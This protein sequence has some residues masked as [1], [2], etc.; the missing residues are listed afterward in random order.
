MRL[1]LGAIE[2]S[3]YQP[4]GEIEQSSLEGLA[5]SLRESGVIQPL[6]VRPAQAP[7][8][9]ELIAG[10]RRWRAAML[11]GLEEVPAIVRRTDDEEAAQLA[12]VENVQ[13]E[14]LNP[15]ERSDALRRLSEAFGWTQRQLA[16]RVGLE[17]STVANLMRLGELEPAIRQMI[18]RNE[19][20][21]GHA[22]A[23]L[24]I[25]AGEARADLARRAAAEG[26]SVRK[27]ES[28]AREPAGA[29]GPRANHQTHTAQA[30]SKKSADLEG[31]ERRLGEHLG[32]RVSIKVSGA[33][34][35]GRISIEFFDLDHFDAVVS[36]MGY[37]AASDS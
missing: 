27:L 36:S 8:R 13:R 25:S 11:A 3:P 31:L 17:R 20:S 14:D 26:W 30:G 28:A 9:Y 2:P 6:L 18:A 12:L 37:R 33:G 24:S 10:E 16:E 29:N 7:G 1:A 35:R 5:Q 21:L 32:T 15:I 23:L 34:N 4:R 22:K 19:L